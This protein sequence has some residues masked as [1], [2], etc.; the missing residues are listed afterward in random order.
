MSFGS[1]QKVFSDIYQLDHVIKHSGIMVGRN[2]L[3]DILREIFRR[4]REYHYVN[5]KFGYP[6]TPSHLGLPTDAGKEDELTTRIYIGG[7]H[8]EDISFFPAVTVRSSNISNYPISFNQNRGTYRYGFQKIVDGY[9]VQTIVRVPTAIVYTGAW[10][11]SFEIKVSSRSLEDAQSIADIILLSLEGT[12]RDDLQQNGLFIK[13]I[14]SSGQQ[15]ENIGE[16]DPIYH[17]SINVNTF[18]EWR[19]EIPISNLVDRIQ[20]CFN[21]DISPNDIPATELTFKYNIE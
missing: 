9:G 5:D 6:K 12:Y 18:S 21:F 16:A 19:R 1:G 11:Q 2:M 20:I 8:R 15:E 10:E 14:S 4:D 17:F 13:S 3:I 7:T